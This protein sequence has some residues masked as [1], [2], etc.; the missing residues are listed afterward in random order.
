MKRKR[1]TEDWVL[2]IVIYTIMILVLFL[3]IY[4]LGYPIWIRASL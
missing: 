2:D 4:P 1:T 3:T